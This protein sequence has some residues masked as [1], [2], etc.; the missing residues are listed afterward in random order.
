MSLHHDAQIAGLFKETKEYLTRLSAVYARLE[1]LP[2]TDMEA[3]RSLAKSAALNASDLDS[4]LS[5]LA[6]VAEEVRSEE[7][8][9]EIENAAIRDDAAR[10]FAFIYVNQRSAL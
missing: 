10:L 2:A 5:D 9:L 3:L 6:N 7:A 8:D 4:A 1:R